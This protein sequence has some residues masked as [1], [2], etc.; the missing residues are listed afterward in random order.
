M[1]G[2]PA[3]A[4]TVEQT[5]IGLWPMGMQQLDQ[6]TSVLHVRDAHEGRAT[7]AKAL[8]RLAQHPDRVVQ[9]LQHITKDHVL[10]TVCWQ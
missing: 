6:H 4:G 9:V 2:K 1:Q 10:E 8:N 3:D 5:G 7:R